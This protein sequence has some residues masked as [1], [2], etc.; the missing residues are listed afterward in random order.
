MIA[1]NNLSKTFYLTRKI[2]LDA[3]KEVRFEIARGEFVTIMGPSGSG[4]ST[5]M[6]IIGCL[7]TPTGGSYALDGREVSG[8]RKKQLARVRNSTIGFVFQSFNLL[9]MLSAWENVALPM[10]YSKDRANRKRRAVSILE[11]VGLGTHVRH[12]P[13]Q[14]SGGECQRVA[15]ARALVNNPE[16][17]LADEPTGNLDWDTGLEIIEIF[18][19]LNRAGKTIV[20]V[21]HE[22][23]IGRMGG[24][25]LRL[26]DG[27]LVADE[28]IG[29]G[30][31]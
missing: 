11:R 8:L 4:K 1:V 5:L 17:I 7:D 25:I 26:R 9:P 22:E 14:M 23:E 27:R 29:G 13:T 10:I 21:T 3:L 24:R 20:V 31:V 19:E 15:I 28:R 12:K 6:S 2:S 30:R 16:I 18:R